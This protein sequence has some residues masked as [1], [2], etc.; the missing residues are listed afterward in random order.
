[1]GAGWSQRIISCQRE[2][3]VECM[4]LTAV[5]TNWTNQLDGEVEWRAVNINW[6]KKSVEQAGV[7]DLTNCNGRWE[8]LNG[9]RPNIKLKVYKQLDGVV[10]TGESTWI[11]MWAEWPAGLSQRK[12]G[13]QR[14][15][16][17]GRLCWNVLLKSCCNTFCVWCRSLI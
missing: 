15:M 11:I 10:R 14:E 6:W 7:N 13:C 12:Q 16:G 9:L 3:G 5:W 8:C 1:M 4:Q 17:D 2:M